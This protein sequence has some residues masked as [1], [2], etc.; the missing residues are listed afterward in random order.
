MVGLVDA[1]VERERERIHRTTGTA[2]TSGSR[3]L[4]EGHERSRLPLPCGHPSGEIRA[5]PIAAD[6]QGAQVRAGHYR[7]A[8][9][10]HRRRAEFVRTQAEHGEAAPG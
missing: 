5:A 3:V 1:P 7:V 4:P 9:R 2:K 10:R 8:K 6:V